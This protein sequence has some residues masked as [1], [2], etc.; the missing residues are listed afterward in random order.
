MKSKA[1]L[2]CK[3]YLL[4][5]FLYHP[6]WHIIQYFQWNIQRYIWWH[7]T[8]NEKSNSDVLTGYMEG[9][10][11]TLQH[12]YSFCIKMP[13][14]DGNTTKK[15]PPSSRGPLHTESNV[16]KFFNLTKTNLSY[17][18]IVYLNLLFLSVY[19]YR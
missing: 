9:I 3:I 4:P 14:T 8:T 12:L 15:E 18:N 5:L 2:R 1:V 10:G 17:L 11:V 16:V 19:R 7:T 6:A 13:E